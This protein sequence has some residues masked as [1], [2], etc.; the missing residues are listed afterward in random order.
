MIG[1]EQLGL[2]AVDDGTTELAA[3]P[4]L[5]PDV[6]LLRGF[7]LAE[8]AALLRAIDTV[9][10]ASPFRHLVTP[11]G[12]RM[13]VAMTNCGRLGW[14]SDRRGYRY[15]ERDP[16]RREPWPAMPKTLRETAL[17]AAAKAGFPGFAPDACLINR[18]DPGAQMTL[19]QDRDE[20]DL[21][22]P[23]VSFSLGLPATFLLGGAERSDRPARLEL[24]HGDVL[25]WGGRSRLRFHGVLPLKPGHHPLIGAHRLNLTFRRAG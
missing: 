8:A 6:A 19:H 15:V 14:S 22:A 16:A 4:E 13:S 7:A 18:Y 10:E 12:R 20:R 9:V 23:I 11:G 25:V 3:A 5:G 21:S 24:H 2:F 1:G 17:R